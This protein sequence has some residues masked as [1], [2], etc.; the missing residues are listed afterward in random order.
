V[1]SEILLRASISCFRELP[2]LLL[3]KRP[4]LVV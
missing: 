1:R 3:R 2:R 4:H